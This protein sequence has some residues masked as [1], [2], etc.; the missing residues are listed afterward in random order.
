MGESVGLH[1][2][3]AGG[4]GA[5]RSGGENALQGLAPEL[6]EQDGRQQRI[7][8]RRADEAAEDRHG[9][10]VQDLA[11][12]LASPEQQRQERQAS[13]QRRH[14]HGRQ[15]LEA[16]AHDEGGAESLP[17]E[18]GEV[19]VVADLENAVARGDAGQR[20]EADH[21]G[22]RQGLADY[23]QRNDAADEGQRNAGEDD[24]RQDEGSVALVEH[25]E[26]QGEGDERQDADD[27]RSLLL[28]PEGPF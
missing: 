5:L 14:Q 13:A 17:F 7:E 21:G 26:D 28:C 27:E 3:G 4:G 10:G 22:D 6:Q 9:H 19:D 12:G 24:D 11:S 20:D 16:A 2:G 25:H 15:A 23:R 1:E 18:E 8:Q